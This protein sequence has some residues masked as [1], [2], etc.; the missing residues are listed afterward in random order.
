MSKSK[1]LKR[2][3][4]KCNKDYTVPYAGFAANSQ[5]AEYY[6][7]GIYFFL[8]FYKWCIC[9]EC[10]SLHS[11]SYKYAR[12]F[13]ILRLLLSV[14]IYLLFLGALLFGGFFLG[15]YLLQY[16]SISSI[17][18]IVTGIVVIPLLISFHLLLAT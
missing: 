3:C 18:V 11:E 5:P 4:C 6:Q 12:F 17:A 15:L 14:F 10:L 1:R 2:C 13:R 16:L 9:T 7:Q 8:P